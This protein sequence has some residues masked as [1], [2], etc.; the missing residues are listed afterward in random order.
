M[1]EFLQ[2]GAEIP[3]QGAKKQSKLKVYSGNEWLARQR[4]GS[5]YYWFSVLL[6]DG[7]TGAG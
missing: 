5:Q 6:E 4:H 2:G 1:L 3:P 7:N